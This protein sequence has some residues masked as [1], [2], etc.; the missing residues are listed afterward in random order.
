MGWHQRQWCSYGQWGRSITMS[1][2][3]NHTLTLCKRVSVPVR[4]SLVAAVHL[5]WRDKQTLIFF[6]GLSFGVDAIMVLDGTLLLDEIMQSKEVWQ[7]LMIIFSTILE[8]I[9]SFFVYL[10]GSAW[11]VWWTGT[12]FVE[13]QE[14]VSTGDVYMGA[15]LMGLWVVLLQQHANQVPWWEAKDLLDSCRRFSQPFGIFIL[16][17]VC[18]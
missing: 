7:D 12:S 3:S 4:R 6:S 10:T 1:L 14:C 16:F 9:D 2:N 17:V 11:E 13:P 8:F 18:Y 15:L 5:V